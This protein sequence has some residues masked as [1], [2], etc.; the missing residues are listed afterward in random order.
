MAW[1]DPATGAKLSHP[2]AIERLARGRVALLG[3]RHDSAA[4]H[5]FQELVIAGLAARV[6]DLHVGFEMFPRH[7]QPVLDAWCGE[8]MSEAEFLRETRWEEVWGFEPEL[9]LPLF[10]LCRDLGLPMF[11]MNVA[12]PVVS[13]IGREGW[14]ALPGE[15]RDW[16]SPAFPA[17][18]AYRRY[19]FAITGGVRPG[20]AAQSPE[21]PVFDRF[22]RA[23]Q[24][25]DRAFA[26]AIAQT[27]V[28]HPE[29][30]VVGIIG[31]GHLEFGLG[32]A[33]Q[34]ADLGI[35]G[36]GLALRGDADETPPCEG[37]EAPIANL[38]F[39]SGAD[40]ARSGA[41]SKR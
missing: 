35:P 19:L 2:E 1:I 31:R 24:V 37:I 40:C 22:V 5:R 4:D 29:R 30:R 14:E 11:A 6:G 27:C 41:V 20:R 26:C 34:L 7:L 21:D 12:R 32:T 13:L 18:A 23:Q 8:G 38:L 15:Y 33:A 17:S 28:G 16:L 36:A 3:E 25:W 10:R 9:Y 39:R